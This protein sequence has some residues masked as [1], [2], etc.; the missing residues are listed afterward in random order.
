[1]DSLCVF[2]YEKLKE[3]TMSEVKE[4]DFLVEEEERKSVFNLSNIWTLF[5]LNWYWVLLSLVVCMASAWLY[6]KYTA[7]VYSSSMKVLVKDSEQKR[8]GYSSIALDEMGFMSNS[9]GFDNEL[10]I[11]KSVA[12]AKRVVK[13]LK[14]YVTYFA[15]GSFKNEELYKESPV[16]VDIVEEDLEK[17]SFPL[18]MNLGFSKDG[19]VL[20]T[21]FDAKNPEKVTSSIKIDQLPDTIATKYGRI[22]LAHNPEPMLEDS[23]VSSPSKVMVSVYPIK[24][25]A[26]SYA[27]RLSASP[28]SK[29]TTVANIG[30]VDTKT[31]RALDYLREL[32]NCYNDDANEDKNE[33]ARKTEEFLSDR[34]QNIRIELD[35][36]EGGMESYKRENELINLSNDATTALSNYTSYQK[37]K[38]QIQTQMSLVKALI[39]YMNDADNYLQIIPANLGLNNASLV[40]MIS[41]YNE[42]VLKRNRYLKGSSEENPLVQQ[43]TRQMSDIWPSIKENMSSVYMNMEMQNKSIEQQFKHFSGRIAQTPTQERVLTNI[44]R[45]RQL[46]SD[47]YLTLLQKREENYIQLYSTASK[48]RVIDEPI[49]AGKISPKNQMIYAGAFAFG[50][51][52]PIALFLGLSLLRYR[53][54]GREDVEQLTKLPILADIPLNHHIKDSKHSIV[55]R[56]NR[57]DMMEEAFR[58]LRT[59]LNFILKSPEKVVLVT[60]CIPGEGKTFVSTNLAMSMALLNKKVLI[61][62]LDIRKPRLVNLFGLV[63]DNRGIVNF[64]NATEADF[65]LLEDQI[66]QTNINPNMYVLPAGIIPPNPA[67]LLASPLLV[68]GIEYLSNIYDYIILDTPPV[69]LVADTL[70]VGHIANTTLFIVRADF[71]HKINFSLINDIA[72]SEKMPKCN[73]VLN[74]IDLKKRKYGHYY[75]TGSY[76]KYGSYGRYGHYGVY[77]KYG[78]SEGDSCHTEK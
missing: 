24:D 67:E 54:E 29:T 36:A 53:I 26:R 20:D 73:I 72:K 1:M 7:P 50:V 68:Q 78:H 75:G 15:E 42:L 66:T 6:L 37:E 43:L 33:V 9:N 2:D 16:F 31:R 41:E 5:C 48:A 74:S 11:I 47:L 40:S 25:I 12:V 52:F 69:G 38:V 27:G 10:E 17:L 21:Y 39:D 76:S 57:N 8:G 55:V 58:G 63:A 3:K 30:F 44:D 62:G 22:V 64:L 4:K 32:V 61:V 14:L 18:R 34:L 70:S 65:K 45:Q 35:E 51:G 60:S 46:K 56:R 59:N 28:T 23:F 13:R 19:V 49:V 77:G 71:S